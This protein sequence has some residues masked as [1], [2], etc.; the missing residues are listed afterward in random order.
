[1][2]AW[3]V[4]TIFAQLEIAQIVKEPCHVASSNRIHRNAF[5]ECSLRVQNAVS[6]PSKDKMEL[7]SKKAAFD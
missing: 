5:A 1:M 7:I 3:Q 4:L 6:M 2:E